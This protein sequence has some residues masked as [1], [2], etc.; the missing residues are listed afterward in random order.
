M[1]EAAGDG[2]L[3]GVRVLD[4]GHALAG[5]FAAALMGDFGA[6]IIKVE[7]LGKGDAGRHMGPAD[8]NGPVWWRS[9]A[10]NKRSVGL[11]WTTD[12]GKKVLKR[13]IR[14]SNVLIENFRPGVLERHGLGPETLFS[15]NPD[16]VVLRISGYGQNGPYSSRPGF[17]KAAEA[18]SGLVHLTGF[19]DGPPLHPGFPLGDMATG[20]MGAYGSVMAIYAIKCGHAR[21]QVIDLPIYETIMR[22]LDFPVPIRTGTSL[23]PSRN[24]NRQPMSFGLSGIFQS[25]DKRWLTYSCATYSVAERLVRLVGATQFL[26][27]EK[28]S[29]LL[30]LSQHDEEINTYVAAWMAD[31]TAAE[32]MEAFD[33][34]Q[35]V[36]ALVYDTDDVLNDAHIQ[37]RG[38]VVAL[39][40]EKTKVVNIVPRMEGTPG[41]V[42]WLGP[43]DVGAD[44]AEV[45]QSVGGFDESEIEE[46]VASGAISLKSR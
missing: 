4:L 29:D 19:P 36:A 8:E 38:N 26:D 39:P 45:L 12:D 31:R 6:D 20:L 21:G 2:P 43:K 37:A 22:L 41:K 44:T 9:L 7:P 5:P 46:L 34:A 14:E 11:D 15:W 40:G 17:G 10:R 13:L 42:R 27:R 35:A 33:K 1:I 25:K 28:Y 3:S 32:V 16:L 18:L 30:T 24:G 23:V